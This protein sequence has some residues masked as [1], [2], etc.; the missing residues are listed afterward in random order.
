MGYAQHRTYQR[1]KMPLSSD[2]LREPTTL[3]A[4]QIGVRIFAILALIT[5]AGCANLRDYR[6]AKIFEMTGRIEI[7]A[8]V[9]DVFAFAANPE[10]DHLWR[11]E[12]RE[13]TTNGP[14]RVGT[15][16][17]EFV[18]IGAVRAYRTPTHIVALEKPVFLRFED[19]AGHNRR[20]IVEREFTRLPDKPSHT[21]MTY[22]VSADS[23]MIG[24][25]WPLPIPLEIAKAVYEIRMRSHLIRLKNY[26]ETRK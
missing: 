22:R 19:L 6:N 7:A 24:D 1:L 2:C 8:P 15:V 10:N 13:F 17:T 12:V 21:Y 5:A 3:G 14:M 16:Y 26:L 18:A 4:Q 9:S 20:F 25:L 11:T 23:R